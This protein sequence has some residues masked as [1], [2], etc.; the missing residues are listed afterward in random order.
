MIREKV[1][2]WTVRAREKEG[3]A[4]GNRLNREAQEDSM[5]NRGEWG[6]GVNVEETDGNFQVTNLSLIQLH[7]L[8]TRR[9][10]PLGASVLSILIHRD[11]LFFR[12]TASFCWSWSTTITFRSLRVCP[13]EQKWAATGFSEVLPRRMPERWLF[14]RS[15][16]ACSVYPRYCCP[17]RSH[18]IT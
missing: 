10:I 9:F 12:R 14:K 15:C 3:C 18:W 1:W 7:N 11:S 4:G 16:K 2:V 6:T 8:S 13:F 17:Q 5:T